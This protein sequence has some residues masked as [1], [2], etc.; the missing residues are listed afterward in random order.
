[1]KLRTLNQLVAAALVS[2]VALSAAAQGGANGTTTQPG[3]SNATAASSASSG[4]ASPGAS[5]SAAT[6]DHGASASR[7]GNAAHHTHAMRHH[8]RHARTQASRGH[9]GES[10]ARNDSGSNAGESQYRAALRRCVEGP[11]AQRDS[12][13][14]QAIQANGR[15]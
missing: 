11:Q 3:T 9:R 13:L 6:S 14:D 5:G 4:N 8:P 7:S 10:M 1:M 15:A 12:C 2:G